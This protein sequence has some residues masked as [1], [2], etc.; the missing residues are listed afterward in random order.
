MKQV[1]ISGVKRRRRLPTF[2]RNDTSV[3]DNGYEVADEIIGW[4][5][6]GICVGPLSESELPLSNYTVSSL[7][8]RIKPNGRVRLILDLSFPHN[9]DV[10]LGMGT[11]CSVNRGSRRIDRNVVHTSVVENIEARRYRRSSVQVRL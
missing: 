2:G 8:T 10:E 9:K 11:P 1:P 4:L 7:T 5:K 6:M 3:S